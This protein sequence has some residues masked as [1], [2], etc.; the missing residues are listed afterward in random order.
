MGFRINKVPE[1]ALVRGLLV[2]ITG[3]IAYVL[4]HQV[5]TSWIEPALTVY[6][7]V[8]PLLA[9]WLIRGVVKPDPARY[10][11]REQE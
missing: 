11:P 5:D 9:G 6:G 2:T 3:V 10:A 4:G 7:L 8:T 1:P